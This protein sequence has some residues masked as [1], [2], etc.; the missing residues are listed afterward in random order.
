LRKA[1]IFCNNNYDDFAPDYPLD[2]V[3]IAADGGAEYLKSQNI[4]PDIL[5]GDFDS[6]SEEI[7]HFFHGKTKVLR[8]PEKKNK[9]D[10]EL[11]MDFCAK[12]G[13][14][15]IV[16]IN[17]VNGQL[18]HSLANIFIAEKYV[19]KGIKINFIN[20]NSEIFVLHGK[21]KLTLKT[22]KGQNVSLIPLS[23]DVDVDIIQ[24]FQYPLIK[25]TLYRVTTRGVSNVAKKQE[26]SVSISAGTLLLIRG[27]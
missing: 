21:E 17:A 15:E 25:E 22:H 20:R 11:A 18:E 23:D 9:T 14:G 13:Y 10:S 19:Q 7:L 4:T 2:G 27:R 8:Y 16:L 12:E 3:I 5:I 24:G 26:V 6:L 1:I